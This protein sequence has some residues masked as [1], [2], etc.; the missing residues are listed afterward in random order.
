MPSVRNVGPRWRR[1]LG[2]VLP[3]VRSKNKSAIKKVILLPMAGEEGFEPSLA[4][5]ESAVLP[6]DYSPV[7]I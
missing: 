4:D 2:F 7:C 3:V 1:E 6:L 5:P